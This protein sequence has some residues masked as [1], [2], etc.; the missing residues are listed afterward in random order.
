MASG[1]SPTTILFVLTILIVLAILLARDSGVSPYFLF[2]TAVLVTVLLIIYYVN[3]K[4]DYTKYYTEN[5]YIIQ[6][7]MSMKTSRVVDGTT[8]PLS[9]NQADGAE[10]T[11]A[12]WLNITGSN[13]S[14]ENTTERTIFHRGNELGYPITCPGLYLDPKDNILRIRMN[15]FNAVTEL[16]EIP[17]IPLD[18]W[19]HFMIILRGQNLDVY[20]NNKL[21]TRSTLTGIPR[22]TLNN[23]YVCPATTGSS[24]DGYIS[25]MRYL[26]HAATTAERDMIVSE[27]PS[28]KLEYLNELS[29]KTGLSSQYYFTSGYPNV[30]S[31]NYA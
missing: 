26:S 2:F 29:T 5:P 17:N 18:E 21:K 1:F 6:N 19:F 8:L 13:F 28:K 25:V 4:A 30:T 27:G 15:T 23:L 9:N 24:L 22:L 3:L 16:T 20:I 11:Y 7:T 14:S 12:M 31:A 10:F